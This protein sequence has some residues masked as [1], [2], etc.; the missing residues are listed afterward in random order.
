M[1][2][3]RA[4]VASMG[5]AVAVVV[6]TSLAWACSPSAYV[7]VN[8]A[9]GPVGSTVTVT[10]NAFNSGPVE[11]RWNAISG[12]SLGTA[13][14]PGFSVGVKIPEAKPGG[15]VIV[16]VQ[17]V[18]GLI[19]GRSQAAFEVASTEASGTT[20]SGD[21]A[22]SR[23]ASGGS[24]TGSTANSGTATVPADSGT[25]TEAEASPVASATP[26]ATTSSGLA[27]ESAPAAA[28]AE[29]T[30][31]TRAAPQ[32]TSSTGRQGAA[33]SNSTVSGAGPASL[34]PSSPAPVDD[35][36]PNERSGGAASAPSARTATADLWGGFAGGDSPV[37]GPGLVGPDAASGSGDSAAIGVGLLSLGL[38]AL[39]SGFGIAETRRRRAT[40]GVTT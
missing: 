35:K 14:G 8:P 22:T 24:R 28:T 13:A 19:V 32:G 38:I 2:A 17:Y 39:G 4:I 30:G 36:V 10:G 18:N 11:I 26:G 5:I 33:N 23:S 31:G 3:R 7:E 37:A 21:G 9:T 1:K 29:S 16:V 6:A 34:A 12:R 25:G 40:T 27:G 20:A 15:H